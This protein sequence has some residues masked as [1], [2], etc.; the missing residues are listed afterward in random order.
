MRTLEQLGQAYS[1]LQQLE[2]KIDWNISKTRIEAEESIPPAGIKRKMRFHIKARAKDQPW[3]VKGEPGEPDFAKGL[4][5]PKVELLMSAELLPRTTGG[6]LTDLER[7]LKFTDL[8]KQV[9]IESDRVAEAGENV[10]PF[11]WRKHASASAG[12]GAA[13]GGLTV[14]LPSTGTV[15]FRI[16]VY[17]NHEPDLF[18]VPTALA[19]VIQLSTGERGE[20]MRALWTYA[21]R[22]NLIEQGGLRTTDAIKGIFHAQQLVAFH[23]VP[24]YLNR[25]LAPPAPMLIEVRAVGAHLEDNY[26]WDMLINTR[27]AAR[28]GMSDL[29]PKLRVPADD[30][31][32]LDEEVSALLPPDIREC[33]DRAD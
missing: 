33:L 18:A 7:A 13:D 25:V 11:E 2:R 19:N 12:A 8:V 15:T 23:H 30:I 9:T 5:I 27:D 3:Q 6:K 21:R 4:N 14:S 29:Y 28:E 20:I 31:R 22:H 32:A 10:G 24:E 26:A 17:P 16:A 1:R